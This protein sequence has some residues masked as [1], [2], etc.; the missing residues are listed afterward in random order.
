[1]TAV[2]AYDLQLVC[3]CLEQIAHKWE[4]VAGRDRKRKRMARV[5]CHPPRKDFL[6]A[7]QL[8]VICITGS[9]VNIYFLWNRAKSLNEAKKH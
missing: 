5:R 9:P 4:W 6:P 2:K 8:E 1:M 7:F 3:A